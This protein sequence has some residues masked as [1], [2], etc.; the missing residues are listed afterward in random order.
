M[1]LPWSWNVLILHSATSLQPNAQAHLDKQPNAS[2]PMVSNLIIKT[3]III[4]LFSFLPLLASR[5]FSIIF[6]ISPFTSSIHGGIANIFDPWG[7]Y[8]LKL[9]FHAKIIFSINH[10]IITKILSLD[11]SLISMEATNKRMCW[12]G[13]K[14]GIDT[15]L[16]ASA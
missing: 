2:D 6:L 4:T 16:L 5:L 11:C 10:I 9:S 1:L 8:F 13:K 12:P 7:S 15:Y 3:K 14:N